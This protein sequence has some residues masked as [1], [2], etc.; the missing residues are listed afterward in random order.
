MRVGLQIVWQKFEGDL[1]LELRVLGQEHLAHAASTQASRTRYRDVVS[2]TRVGASHSPRRETEPSRTPR[3]TR[4]WPPPGAAVP[5]KAPSVASSISA[6]R[7]HPSI[8]YR[9]ASTRFF[10]CGLSISPA[11]GTVCS[12]WP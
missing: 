7:A 1:A 11:D 12:G 6:S 2:L 3:Q 10:S 4:A 9:R 5:S 8:G